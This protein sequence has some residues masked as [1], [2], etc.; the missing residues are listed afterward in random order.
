MCQRVSLLQLRSEQTFANLYLKCRTAYGSLH[1][2]LRFITSGSLSSSARF[3]LSTAHSRGSPCHRLLDQRIQSQ[4][5]ATRKSLGS[6]ARSIL[7]QLCTLL[8]RA[9]MKRIFSVTSSH[10]AAF[11]L[12]SYLYEVSINSLSPST[13]PSCL[14]TS[15]CA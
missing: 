5:S 4:L 7:M 10:S 6:V 12:W 2:T 1:S 3:P 11:S 13:T 9:V 14:M 15:W 8:M